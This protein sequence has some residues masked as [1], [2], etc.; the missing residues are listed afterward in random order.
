M[1]ER[2]PFIP[3]KFASTRNDFFSGKL[4]SMKRYCLTITAFFI[5]AIV[6]CQDGSLLAVNKGNNTVSLID[7]NTNKETIALSV[8][9][10]HKK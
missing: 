10:D 1:I 3:N 4:I 7:L 5:A 8:G 6:Y 2:L 9:D